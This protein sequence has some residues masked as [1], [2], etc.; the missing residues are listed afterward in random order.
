MSRKPMPDMD[1]L[2]DLKSG[3]TTHKNSTDTTHKPDKQ[4]TDNTLKRYDV[5]FNPDDWQA[6]KMHFESQGLTISAGLRMIVKRYMKDE[7]I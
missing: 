7:G 6:L 3:K 1:K 2:Y 5:R 4:S